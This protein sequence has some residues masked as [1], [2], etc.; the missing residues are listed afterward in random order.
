MFSDCAIGAPI[1]SSRPDSAFLDPG[2]GSVYGERLRVKIVSVASVSTFISQRTEATE[3]FDRKA[4]GSSISASNYSMSCRL[5][6]CASD[7]SAL[8]AS[9]AIK[10]FITEQILKEAPRSLGNHWTR[11]AAEPARVSP[12][13]QLQALTKRYLLAQTDSSHE[14]TNGNP[15]SAYRT[16]TVISIP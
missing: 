7:E 8:D 13:G 16:T 6:T 9:P 3:A 4:R 2:D 1:N 12:R 14:G 5:P 10:R 15:V 11:I